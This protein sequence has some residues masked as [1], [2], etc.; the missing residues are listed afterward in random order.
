MLFISGYLAAM[1]WLWFTLLFT[2]VLIKNC[3]QLTN[4]DFFF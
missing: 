4:R 1:I 2:L 3:C